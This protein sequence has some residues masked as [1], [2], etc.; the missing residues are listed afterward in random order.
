[1]GDIPEPYRW[2]CPYRCG[3]SG[4]AA[5]QQEANEAVAL[6]AEFCDKNPKNK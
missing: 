2:T 1:M 3:D 4:T 6:H 5:T